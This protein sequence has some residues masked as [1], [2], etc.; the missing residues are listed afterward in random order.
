MADGYA[1]S[2]GKVGVCNA[3]SGPG[4]LNLITGLATAHFDSIPVVAVTG[5]VAA[6]TIGTDALHE[7][8]AIGSS[9]SVIKHSYRVMDA[10]EIPA[11]VGQAF[12]I[13]SSG[14]PGAVLIDLPKDVQ[15]QRVAEL[16]APIRRRPPNRAPGAL[17]RLVLARMPAQRPRSHRNGAR[18]GAGDLRA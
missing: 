12:R 7:S 17:D 10:S 16:R 13:A 4:A 18:L 2:S 14:R 8:D 3:T 9:L 5:Q 11:V 15:Q 6:T 1:R